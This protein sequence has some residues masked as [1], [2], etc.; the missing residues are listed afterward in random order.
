MEKRR[1]R[2][3]IEINE[4]SGVTDSDIHNAFQ[5]LTWDASAEA[6]GFR[7]AADLPADMSARL[8][9]A[10]SFAT[11]KVP[12][13]AGPR[14]LDVGCGTGATVGELVRR[15]L[16]DPSRVVGLDLA[17]DMAAVAARLHPRSEF[18]AGDFAGGEVEGYGPFASVL[19]CMSLHDLPE[20]GAALARAV[21]LC[22]RG[23][24]VVVTHP[25]GASHVLMQHRKNPIMVR[26][27]LPT[28]SQLEE[29]CS[30]FEGVELIHA[31]AAAGSPKDVAEGYLAVLELKE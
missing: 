27:P 19:F 12:P 15:R 20:P 6:R 24:R 3:L 9:R 16:L 5:R 28:A 1:E 26:N 7:G 23:G 10:L 11:D 2:R 30:R 17:P 22:E 8:G 25:R 18:V 21:G 31:P 4:E 29:I 13:T 14:L